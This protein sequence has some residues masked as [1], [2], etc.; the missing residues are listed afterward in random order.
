MVVPKRSEAGKINNPSVV[1]RGIIMTLYLPAGLLCSHLL[2]GQE[3]KVFREAFK[4]ME[5]CLN[6]TG[7]RLAKLEEAVI[8]LLRGSVIILTSPDIVACTSDCRFETL[9]RFQ[10]QSS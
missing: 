2:R 1:N 10:L 9:S 7:E 4:R 8:F 5:R 3:F 6:K